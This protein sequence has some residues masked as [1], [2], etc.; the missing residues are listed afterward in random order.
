MVRLSGKSVH[1]IARESGNPADRIPGMVFELSAAELAATDAYEVD[2]YARV[3]VTLES[4]ARAF[5][6]VGP[7]L[8]A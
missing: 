6:Y 8:G 5:A 1:H 4:G 2:A 3:E 7:P